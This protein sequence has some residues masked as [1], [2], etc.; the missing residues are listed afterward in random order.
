MHHVNEP[1]LVGRRKLDQHKFKVSQV[2]SASPPECMHA[3][4][5][6]I[7]QGLITTRDLGLLMA[8]LESDSLKVIGI[9]K[10]GAQSNMN[11]AI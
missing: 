7:R 2:I 10:M 5:V 9:I 11:L 6:A 8:E 1:R 4:L 3:E